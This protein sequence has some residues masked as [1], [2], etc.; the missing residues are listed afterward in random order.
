MR[1][2]TFSS[3]TTSLVGIVSY[4]SLVRLM[5][6]ESSTGGKAPAVKSIIERDPLSVAPETSTLEAI[7][8][9]R[10]HHVSCLPVV[11]DGKLVGIVSERDFLPIAHELLKEKLGKE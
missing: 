1:S 2:G 3:K 8:L 5:A 7:D 10:S 9:M 11:K 6:E 4:R